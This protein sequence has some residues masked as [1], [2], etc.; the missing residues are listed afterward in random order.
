MYDNVLQNGMFSMSIPV[1]RSELNVSGFV[2]CHL[3]TQ[4]SFLWP[5]LSS[6]VAEFM[7]CSCHI[8]QRMFARK[9]IQIT[10]TM[11]KITIIIIKIH[12]WKISWDGNLFRNVCVVFALAQNSCCHLSL[13][14]W[15]INIFSICTKNQIFWEGF[16]H[17]ISAQQY[18]FFAT[19]I[20]SNFHDLLT[21]FL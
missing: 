11:M 16:R 13:D 5:H 2:G 19:A 6:V 8:A 18:N 20:F 1:S 21:E 7:V 3:C 17:E 15:S 9:C 14:T 10:T 12:I 4:I